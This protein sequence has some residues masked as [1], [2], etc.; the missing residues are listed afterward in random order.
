MSNAVETKQ[1]I[2]NLISNS[3]L[4]ALDLLVLM[5]VVERLDGDHYNSSSLSNEL[6]NFS[7]SY[8]CETWEHGNELVDT[9]KKHIKFLEKAEQLQRVENRRY[10]Y[11]VTLS[12]RGKKIW[13]AEILGE[14]GEFKLERRFLSD[15]EREYLSEYRSKTKEICFNLKNGKIYESYEEAGRNEIRKFWLNNESYESY[16]QAK[17]AKQQS[18]QPTKKRVSHSQ[19]MKLAWALARELAGSS[20]G[21]RAKLSQAMRTLNQQFTH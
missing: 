12:T 20:K 5:P 16:E 11:Q 21:S 8:L 18:E 15:E 7:F 4:N 19:F 14:G 6:T 17:Q 1:A 9:L 2:K 10:D 13:V 3:S